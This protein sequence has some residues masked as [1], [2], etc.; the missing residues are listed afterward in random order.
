M[1]NVKTCLLSYPIDVG[2]LKLCDLL[3]LQLFAVYIIFGMC[4]NINNILVTVL[5]SFSHRAHLQP[6]LP[7]VQGLVNTSYHLQYSHI[8]YFILSLL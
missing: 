6:L 7:V 2:M 4:L 3:I 5:H 1:W 8:S